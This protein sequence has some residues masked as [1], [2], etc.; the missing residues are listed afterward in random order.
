MS[1]VYSKIRSFSQ[2]ICRAAVCVAI[3]LFICF[4]VAQTAHAQSMSGYVFTPSSGNFTALSGATV[5]TVAGGDTNNGYYP[6]A[7]I[8]FNFRYN[9][10]VYTQVSASTNGWMGFGSQGSTWINDLATGVPRPLVAPLWDDLKVNASSGSVSYLTTGTAPNR[11]FTMQ[12]LNMNWDQQAQTPAISF[13]AKLYEGTNVVRFIYRQEANPVFNASFGASIGL[14]ATGTHSGNFISLNNSGTNPSVST[15]TETNNIGTKPATGQTYTFTPQVSDLAVSITDA[16]DPVTVGT[17]LTYTINLINNGPHPASNAWLTDDIPNDTTFVSLTQNTGPAFACTT[18][19]VGE[20]G[21]VACSRASFASGGSAS[22]S[23]VV[24]VNSAATPETFLSNT[25]SASSETTDLNAA[26][27]SATTTTTVAT[28]VA[29]MTF[30]VTRSDDRNNPI[31][32][33]GDCSLREAVNAAN[34]SYGN[35]IQFSALFDSPQVIILINDGLTISKSMKILGKGANLTTVSG[36]NA[37][38]VIYI[39]QRLVHVTISGL[40][41]ANGNSIGAGGGMRNESFG[42]VNLSNCAFI[43]N[44]SEGNGGGL[45]DRSPSWGTGTL[46]ITGCTFSGNN[47]TEGGA[48]HLQNNTTNVTNTTISGNFSSSLYGGGGIA[49]YNS[50]LTLINST[51]TGNTSNGSQNNG[52]AGGVSNYSSTATTTVKNS[53]IAGNTGFNPDVG[54]YNSSFTSNGYNFIGKSDGSTGFTGINDQ[55][56]TIAAPKD[57]LLLP[58]GNYGGTTQ[59]HALAAGSSAFDKGFSF[60]SLTDQR[61]LNRPVDLAAYPNAT[62]GGAD[63]GAFEAQTAPTGISISGTVF[64]RTAPVGSRSKAVSGVVM[65]AGAG[66]SATTSSLGAYVLE[67]LT[68]GGVYTVTPS[69]TGNGNGITAFDA[70][71]VLRCVAAGANCTLTANQKLAADTDGD[72]NVTAFDATQ[73]LR[74]VAANGSNANTGQVGNWKFIDPSK[75][76]NPLSASQTNQNYT[77]YLIGEVDGDWIP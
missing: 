45:H 76:Y 68:T 43:N 38:R 75:T 60:G 25:V 50:A 72:L 65:S 73:I 9:D 56:G 54:N 11:V 42:T 77:A 29:P 27:N 13:Q 66:N 36:N 39:E 49:N 51:V 62:N 28:D 22:F 20:T 2:I 58:L 14:T 1:K 35:T 37:S 6:L 64:Y 7:P 18:P 30:T 40:A 21:A 26:N 8:G 47:G 15:T 24:K 57:P 33:P 59:T 12:W 4:T 10:I 63:I 5:Q 19:G 52:S 48:I 53:I 74:F 55:V 31:C 3:A 17:N 69:K 34:A 61:G 16:P 67:S 71:L 44:Q 32:A 46:N 41:I 70:T 23:L